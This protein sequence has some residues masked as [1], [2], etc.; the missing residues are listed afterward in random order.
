MMIF[1]IGEVAQALGHTNDADLF[2]RRAANYRNVQ[3]YPSPVEWQTIRDFSDGC[4]H[5]K[6]LHPVC[7]PQGETH[8]FVSPQAL[9]Y[10]K[11]RNVGPSYGREP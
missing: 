7:H 6:S 9:G 2:H 3:G 1:V 10:Y 5:L 11:G 8:E 4:I